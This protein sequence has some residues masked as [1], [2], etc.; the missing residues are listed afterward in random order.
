MNISAPFI[1][2]R[3]HD[4]A[5]DRADAGG[6]RRVLQPAGR[7]A[8]G[9]R[10]PDDHG[11]GEPARRQ[12][13]TMAGSVAAPLERHLGTIAGSART[14]RIGVG[15]SQILQFDLRATSMG[16]R[17][18]C[19]RRSTPRARIC[20]PRSRPIPAIAGEPAEAPVLILALTSHAQRPE[21]YDA[22]SGGAAKLLQ[23]QGVGNVELGGAALPSVRVEVNPLALSRGGIA[24]DVRTA[25]QSAPPPAAA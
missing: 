4:P 8:A 15:S 21:I 11:A 14:S 17:A 7:A 20:P 22:V 18:M 24:E 10:F 3:R 25:L 2:G 1:A 23:V 5:D 9:G 12:P 6:H 19:R 13:S 16:R